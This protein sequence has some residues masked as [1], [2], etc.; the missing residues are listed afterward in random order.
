MGQQ[1]CEGEKIALG[2]AL[3]RGVNLNRGILG[4]F[5]PY[6]NAFVME[7]DT[8]IAGAT[9]A[10]ILAIPAG[11]TGVYNAVVDWGDGTTSAVTAYND[12]NLTHDYT[13]TT[14]AGV[15]D[16]KITGTFPWLFFNNGGDKL[17]LLKI[18]NW[19]D[20]GFALLQSMCHGCANLVSITSY[21]GKVA[22]TASNNYNLFNGCSSLEYADLRA[23]YDSVI[24]G[25]SNNWFINNTKLKKVIF[26]LTKFST[27]A[28]FAGFFSG[29]PALEDCGNLSAFEDAAASTYSSFFNGASSVVGIEPQRLDISAINSAAA[30]LANMFAGVTIS[31]P[32]YDATLIDFEAQAAAYSGTNANLVNTVVHFGNSK[33]SSGGAAEAARASLIST[34]GWTITDGGAA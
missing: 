34:Y 18:K 29:A 24:V 1:L 33:F 7:F 11:N 2:D 12:A 6:G 16:V 10:G 9:G 23:F 17:K 21:S 3:C 27:P 4:Q 15:Y 14:G 5:N 8:T 30:S 25:T 26:G 13:A 31:T 20:V 32:N 19:G 28:G 22:V